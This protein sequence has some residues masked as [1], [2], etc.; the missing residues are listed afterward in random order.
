VA[1]NVLGVIN[2]AWYWIYVLDGWEGSAH[3]GQVFND[4]LLRGLQV[5]EW[6][7]HLGVAIYML[8]SV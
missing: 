1:Q 6:R 7:Y 5:F 4:T 2:V 3:D 8:S